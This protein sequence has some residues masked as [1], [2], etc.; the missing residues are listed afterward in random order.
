MGFIRNP[1]IKKVTSTYDQPGSDIPRFLP[2][3]CSKTCKKWILIDRYT[4]TKEDMKNYTCKHTDK[5]NT[6]WISGDDT[7][8]IIQDGIGDMVKQAKKNECA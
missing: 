6:V 3:Q 1:Q 2:F 7:R 4:V 8:A 5:I